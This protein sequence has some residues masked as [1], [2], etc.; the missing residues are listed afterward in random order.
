MTTR[1][2][3]A[4]VWLG[5]FAAL[6]LALYGMTEAR[7]WAMAEL[8]TPEARARQREWQDAVAKQIDDPK[9]PVKRRPVKSTEPPMLRLLRDH[10]AAACAV[11]LLAVTIFYW[12]LTFI[13]RGMLRAKQLHAR[14]SDAE[15]AVQMIAGS[16]EPRL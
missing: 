13:I 8:D 1:R 16:S 10:F 4:F 11:N 2:N 12:F 14:P 15:R 9:Y 7:R 5:Y 3:F 6:A